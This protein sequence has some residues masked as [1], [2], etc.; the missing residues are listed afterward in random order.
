MD[1]T[2]S[3]MTRTGFRATAVL[4]I[5]AK[6]VASEPTRSVFAS[7]KLRSD[8][9]RLGPYLIRAAWM[10]SPMRTFE[11]H[12]T[13]QRLQ[14][15]QYLRALSKKSGCLR[16]SRS[17]SGPACFGPGKI[18]FTAAT[19]QYTVQTVHLMHCSKLFSL[20]VFCWIFMI[21]GC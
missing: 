14:L 21:L 2:L 13:S 12:D 8:V 6:G 5:G 15:R 10:M 16:R 11:G 3:I 1:M 7:T 20:T 17:P 18:G 4:T 9:L 19:G